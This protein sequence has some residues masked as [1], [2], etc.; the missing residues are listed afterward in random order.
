[1][2]KHKYKFLDDAQAAVWP[3]DDNIQIASFTALICVPVVILEKLGTIFQVKVWTLSRKS[4][5]FQKVFPTVCKVQTKA[6]DDT[7]SSFKIKLRALGKILPKFTT[8]TAAGSQHSFRNKREKFYLLN[9]QF[10][11]TCIKT[12]T[13]IAVHIL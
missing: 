11:P 12:G 6:K 10:Y 13:Y 5:H 9:L 2:C 1:M 7:Q 3:C 4:V 8:D